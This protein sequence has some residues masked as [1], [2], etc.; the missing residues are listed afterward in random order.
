MKNFRLKELRLKN[1]IQQ[2]ELA[3]LF[4]ILPRTFRKWE[5]QEIDI[6]SS[7]LIALAQYFNVSLDYL[8]GIDDVPNRKNNQ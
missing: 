8:V 5:T 3:E 4:D 6:P 1:N 2:K 7:K